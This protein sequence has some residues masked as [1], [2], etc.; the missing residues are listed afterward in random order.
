MKIY[1]KTGDEGQ[2]QVYTDDV[3]RVKKHDRILECYG[4]LDELNA[5]T[6]RL[7]CDLESDN[8]PAILPHIQQALLQVGFAISASTQL[9]DKDLQLLEQEIDTLD[10]QLPALTEFIIPG[11]TR[12]A[13]QA[14][15]CR[16]VTRRA[17]RKLV[18]LSEEHEVLPLCLA[19]VNRLSDFFF[20]F[21]RWLNHQS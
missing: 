5:H 3:L 9:S 12:A 21:A 11:G 6:G 13:A 10:N 16:T 19:Y 18:A 8:I 7:I 2:T 1:T 14:H 20:V 17:E 4:T 15:V